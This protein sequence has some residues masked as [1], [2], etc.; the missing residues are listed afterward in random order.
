MGEPPVSG[1]AGELILTRELG[2]IAING[3]RLA[4]LEGN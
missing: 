3:G 2:T 4:F 1:Q